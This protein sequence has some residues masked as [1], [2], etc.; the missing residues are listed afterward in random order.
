MK[1]DW[2]TRVAILAL[3][4]APRPAPAC[5][6]YAG[7]GRVTFREETRSSKLILYGTLEAAPEGAGAGGTRLRIVE[8]VRPHPALAGRKSL[9]LLRQVPVE[10]AA[11]FLVF[12]DV[13]G[14]KIDPYR[15]VPVTPAAA[16]YLKGLLAVETGGQ[17]RLLRYC[18]EYL[19]HSD[20]E[21]AA[22]AY[23]EFIKSA[24]I[25]IGRAARTAS[26]EKLRGWLRSP[27]TPPERLR[28][29]GFLLGHCGGD[30]DATLLRALAETLAGQG[31]PPLFDGVL[32]GYALLKPEEGWAYVRAL[33]A[34]PAQHF[35]VRYS[36]LRAARFFWDARPDVVP[37][38]KVLGVLETALG[39]SDIADL[40]IE[41]LRGWRCWDLTDQVLALSTQ[42]S[43]DHPVICRAILRYALQCP[44][45]E[46]A[47]FVAGVRK[48][49]P[50]LVEGVEEALEG[51]PLKR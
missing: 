40:P 6:F 34:D 27:H 7:R 30:R 15:G 51:G 24:D 31:A 29:Y 32:T 47:A 35:Q 46:A 23:A 44:R 14:G 48:A 8:V 39:Q 43:H 21:V 50:D 13:S 20:K 42:P 37:K 33:L 4:L 9:D 1:G 19:E 49:S 28:L 12:C 18:F 41:Y 17:A 26:P 11:R 3:L 22:D 16:D 36:G 10:G 25:D 2:V 45:P 38:K 5:G